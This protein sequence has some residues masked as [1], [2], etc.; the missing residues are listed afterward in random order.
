MNRV[1]P[2]CASA[3][4]VLGLGLVVMPAAVTT[5][6]AD[7]IGNC[8]TTT[9]TIIAVDFAHWGG[10]VVRGCGVDDPSG[11]ALSA[12]GRFQHGGRQPRRTGVHLPHRQ[13]G[14]P[15]AE[16]STRRPRRTRASSRR[17]PRR[18]GRTGWRPSVRTAGRTAGSVRRRPPRNR[19]RS[20]CGR[21]AAPT[22]A[23]P[24]G[25]QCQASAP[26][27]S[28]PTDLAPTGTGPSPGPT[29]TQPGV[30]AVTGARARHRRPGQRR[31]MRRHP[32]RAGPDRPRSITRRARSPRRAAPEP[33]ASRTPRVR[34]R[35]ARNPAQRAPTRRPR[36]AGRRRMRRARRRS[37]RQ[38]PRFRRIIRRDRSS[39]LLIG[40]GLVAVLAAGTGWSMLRR[41]RRLA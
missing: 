7:P 9:G 38:C 4:L 12:R 29:P 5:A 13:P 26:T 25:T 24:P 30:G 33:A 34:R 23:A 3:G 14:V 28:A 39:P 1:L 40:I 41:R 2:A 10:P 20:S 31:P 36:S 37:S 17:P 22:S 32:R 8:T 21:S 18:T 16:L 11:Y 19:A 6:T 35:P 15:R 27:R